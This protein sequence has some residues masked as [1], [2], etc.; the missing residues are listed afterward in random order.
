MLPEFA[1]GIEVAGIPQTRSHELHG[2]AAH[3]KFQRLVLPQWTKANINIELR[4]DVY[5]VKGWRVQLF[6]AFWKTNWT[7]GSVCRDRLY[8]GG[9]NKWDGWLWWRIV[10]WILPRHF[11]VS[12]VFPVRQM[13]MPNN[14]GIMA[15]WFLFSCKSTI[16]SII[17]KYFIWRLGVQP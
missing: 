9:G 5:E 17:R 13:F 14:T 2:E 16:R 12:M 11:I 3:F 7:L 1:T 6:S 4:T 15:D 8:A 10:Q